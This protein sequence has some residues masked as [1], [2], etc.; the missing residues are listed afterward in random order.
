MSVEDELILV[1]LF[2]VSSKPARSLVV[3]MVLLPVQEVVSG[4]ANL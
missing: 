3:A 2:E 1:T 4:S